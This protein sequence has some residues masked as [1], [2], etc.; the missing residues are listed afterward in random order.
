MIIHYS[1][2]NVDQNQPKD[3]AVGVMKIAETFVK[4]H[5]EITTIIIDM[6]PRD[7]TYSFWIAKLDET[8]KILKEKCK[9]LPR[10]Y[11]IDQD[12]DWVKSNLILDEKLYYKDFLH[13]A[14]TGP[15]KFS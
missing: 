2:N 11:F 4:N 7:N 15:D 10:T 3:I 1:T 9:N 5:P 13:L 6:L 12:E 8:R 14:E